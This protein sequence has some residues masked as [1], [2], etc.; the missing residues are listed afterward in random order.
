MNRITETIR[1]VGVNDT[2]KVLF[3]SL[4]PLPKGV[5]YNSYLVF[6]QKTALVDTADAAFAEEYLAKVKAEAGDRTIDYLI[7]NHMEPD[8]SALLGRVREEWPQIRIVTTAKAVPMIA[9]YHGLTD[10]IE[11]VKEGDVL[12]LGRGVT[13]QFFFAPMV[14]WPEV[15]VTYYAAEKTLFSADAFGTF[16]VVEGKVNACKFEDYREEMTRY[17]ANIVGKF[18][19]PVQAALKKLSGLE[20]ARVCSTHGPVW[21]DELGDVIALYDKLSRYE[22]ERGG[23]I[24]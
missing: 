9:G 20:I 23:C 21:E 22:G 14:H 1:Y 5:S 15:M 6:G 11:I 2:S 10:N 12:D 4:W 8:H 7:V 16:G 24:V 3:E 13:L 17:Y 18:G 19:A